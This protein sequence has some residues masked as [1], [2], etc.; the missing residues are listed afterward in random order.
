M[1]SLALMICLLALPLSS[2]ALEIPK[3]GPYDERVKFIDY[4][5]AEVVGVTAHY[6]FSTHIQLAEGEEILKIGL[7]DRTAW[8]VGKM[9]NHLFIKPI[10]DQ[11][12]TNMTVLSDRRVYNFVLDARKP[13]RQQKL[14]EMFFQVVFR[15]PE[16]EARK[17]EEEARRAEEETRKA[18]E[19]AQQK[20]DQD[21]LQDKLD[22]PGNTPQNWNYWVKGAEE[23]SPN[24]AYDDR[25]FT[26]LTF[27]NN[28]EMPAVYVENADGSESLVNVHVE[29][30]VIAVHKI[31]KKLVLRKG[32]LVACVFNRAYD[33]DGISNTSG[34]T[35]PGV[36]RVIKGDRHG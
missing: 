17:A 26:Y 29:G 27:A 35:V 34:T 28:K 8:E 25:R 21:A 18:Q 12:G 6:G 4:N 5:A 24:V 16:E 13:A 10:G 1:K 19:L 33:P 22:N 23:L 36:K 30:D 11:A 20:A 7:G 31:A 9:G 32:K 2:L 3:G 15:Y 14:E